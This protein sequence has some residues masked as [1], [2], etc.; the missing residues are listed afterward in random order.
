MGSRGV[1]LLVLMALLAGSA[2]SVA[3]A[4]D[5]RNQEPNSAVAKVFAP[6]KP[7]RTPEGGPIPEAAGKDAKKL[8]T[9][10]P[11]GAKEVVEQPD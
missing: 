4:A 6:G 2:P 8:G 1:L 11:E 5:K 7:N 9:E 3:S 10:V